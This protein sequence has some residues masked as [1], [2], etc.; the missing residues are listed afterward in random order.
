VT[1]LRA[2]DDE[3]PGRE[4]EGGRPRLAKA[5]DHGGEATG[6]ELGVAAA[7]GDL[8]QIETYSQVGCFLGIDAVRRREVSN[9][10]Y[11]SG[12]EGAIVKKNIQRDLIYQWPT[13]SVSESEENL[14]NHR[15]IL[16]RIQPAKNETRG[17]ARAGDIRIHEKRE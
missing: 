4:D 16:K 6:V 12:E 3:L 2:R 5:H 9:A 1:A 15:G 14:Q 17:I 7:E 8:L 13:C 11:R 10:N